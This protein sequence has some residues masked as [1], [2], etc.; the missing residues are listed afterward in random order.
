MQ[1]KSLKKLCTELKLNKK[2]NTAAS[3]NQANF[4][5]SLC[6]YPHRFEVNYYINFISHQ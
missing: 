5:E 6:L 1:I 4:Q 2:K 3:E